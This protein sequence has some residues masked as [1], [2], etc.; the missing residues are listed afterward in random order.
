MPIC[1]AIGVLIVDK[2]NF[3]DFY[4]LIYSII[5]IFII[6]LLQFTQFK[7]NK[8][9]IKNKEIQE[10]INSNDFDEKELIIVSDEHQ[11][12]IYCSNVFERLIGLPSSLIINKNIFEIPIFSKLIDDPEFNFLFPNGIESII[13][14]LEITDDGFKIIFTDNKHQL[15][16]GSCYFLNLEE[17]NITRSSHPEIREKQSFSQIN[18][19]AHSKENESKSYN[20]LRNILQITGNVKY[21]EIFSKLPV[22]IYRTTARGE[23]IEANEALAEIL[24]A[25]SI[26]EL[27]TRS[28]YDFYESS[29]TRE[30]LLYL[31][32]LS[33]ELKKIE[34]KLRR[35]DG[36]VIWVYDRA[37]IHYSNDGKIKYI[38][39]IL[40]DITE[41]KEAELKLYHSQQRY[42]NLFKKLQDVF[43]KID[44]QGNIIQ[45]SPSIE[46]ITGYKQSDLIN[47]NI[48]DYLINENTSYNDFL[49]KLNKTGRINGYLIKVKHKYNSPHYFLVN[50]QYTLGEDGHIDGI[51]GIARDVTETI[52]AKNRVSILYHIAENINSASNL[53]ELYDNI[54]F[55]LHSTLQINNFYIALVN[56]KTGDIEFPYYKDDQSVQYDVVNLNDSHSFTAKVIKNGELLILTKEEI[57]RIVKN[58]SIIYDSM[59]HNWIGIPLK[60]ANRVIGAI[61]IMNLDP[62]KLADKE[63][64]GLLN[65]IAEQIAIAIDRNIMIEEVRAACNRAELIFTVSPSCLLVIDLN[66]NIISCNKR[67]EELTGYSS[68]EVINKNCSILSESLPDEIYLFFTDSDKKGFSQI[69]SIIRTKYG[70]YKIVSKNFDYL[71]D[72]ESKI[73]GAIISLVDITKI[74]ETENE[75]LWQLS[76]NYAIAEISRAIISSE[77]LDKLSTQ[78]LNNLCGLTRTDF[79]LIIYITK[80]NNIEIS[81][82]FGIESYNEEEISNKLIMIRELWLNA[83]ENEEPMLINDSNNKTRFSVLQRTF[84]DF[85]SFILAPAISSREL[86][87]LVILGTRKRE[88][89]H[90]DLEL[91]NRFASLFGIAYQ[92]FKAEQSIR[93]ALVKEQELSEL[94]SKFIMMVSHEYRTPLSAIILSS[95]ILKEYG[96]KLSTKEKEKHYERIN[97]SIKSM[98]K[99]LDDIIT[100]N[101]IDSGLVQF[102]PELIDIESFIKSLVHE[103]NL[104]YRNKCKINLRFHNDNGLICLDEKL[105][106]QI[107]I[108]LLSNAIKYSFDGSEVDFDVLITQDYIEFVI[109]DYGLGIPDEDK[110]NL[111][112]PFF[113]GSNVESI[114]GTGLG[115][116]LVKNCVD[117]H[118]GSIN[119]ESKFGVGTKFDVII[120]TNHKPNQSQS[121]L[122]K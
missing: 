96:D 93:A 47:T 32:G 71:K 97:Q 80:S 19:T 28:V 15:G 52:I 24:G 53:K 88:Y 2:I 73:I 22:G 87:G 39:G 45:L 102:N 89:Q 62:L 91:A 78:I 76:A 40:E 23:I 83:I 41:R 109:K 56:E 20:I 1:L 35:L 65:T 120:P 121:K 85:N 10:S 61:G 107:L 84:P 100:F 42:A 38:D 69:E 103:L 72:N 12:V 37:K 110:K 50:S 99:L 4:Y 21:K 90:K 57:A 34:I 111:F 94:K 114:S 108:N 17:M 5:I 67:L 58:S 98:T 36:K 82:G 60:V 116:N 112:Q 55:T 26:E 92:R 6:S 30:K 118:K 75:L 59:P 64:I 115:L 119:F 44:L 113:R 106:R 95:E 70:K 31:Q 16:S 14:Y 63:E 7:R 122:S 3:C 46:K 51:D 9:F 66:Y 48:R 33:D 13:C 43:F 104:V 77:N 11:K 101:K 25:G 49:K 79:A 81:S 54:Y 86:Q 105:I 29:A 74:K 8:R 18:V 27:Y 117:L 68:D